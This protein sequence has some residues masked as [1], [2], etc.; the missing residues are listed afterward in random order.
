MEKQGLIFEDT[1][2][3]FGLIP[4]KRNGKIIGYTLVLIDEAMTP[5]SS[6]II[7]KGRF[8]VCKQFARDY[9][10]K[11]NWDG[12]SKIS[13]PKEFEEQ[14]IKN[15]RMIKKRME[16]TFSLFTKRVLLLYPSILC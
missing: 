11:I 7:D 14:F 5:D 3:E 9:S 16:N 4:I 10:K 1:K 2:F 13:F 8:N 6:R 12:E 15:Y